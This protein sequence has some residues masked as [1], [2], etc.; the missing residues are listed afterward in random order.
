[1]NTTQEDPDNPIWTADD[2]RR[3]R[4]A[5]EVHPL[6]IVEQLVRRPEKVETVTMALARGGSL[7]TRAQLDPALWRQAA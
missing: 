6:H 5:D 2:F 1:M 4:P 3:A 7:L